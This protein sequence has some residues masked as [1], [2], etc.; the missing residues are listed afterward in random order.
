MTTH[1]A[2]YRLAVNFVEH[3]KVYFESAETNDACVSYVL[4]LSYVH[5]CINTLFTD[6]PDWNVPPL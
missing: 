6:A 2:M 1:L 4:H 3:I 5:L